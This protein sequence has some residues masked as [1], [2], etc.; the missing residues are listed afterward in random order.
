MEFKLVD[1]HKIKPNAWNPNEMKT[2]DFQR[3][4]E[5]IK[6]EGILDPLVLRQVD[7]EYEIVDGAHRFKAAKELGIQVLPAYIAEPGDKLT[8]KKEAMISTI[9]YKTIQGKFNQVKYS[10]LISDLQQKMPK[11]E[12]K[13]R[14]GLSDNDISRAKVFL[15][16]DK[17]HL[18][19]PD[20]LLAGKELSRTYTFR[21]E[22]QDNI[23]LVMRALSVT[24][25]KDNKDLSFV[26]MCQ[27]YLTLDGPAT[28]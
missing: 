15:E 2:R 18:K 11:D 27:R 26:T 9:N 16:V 21:V 12:L 19:T 1:L 3:L 8:E 10:K 4:K 6:T 28:K 5:D 24:G 20:K 22:G 25:W 17:E 23:D 7:G 13:K 14:I